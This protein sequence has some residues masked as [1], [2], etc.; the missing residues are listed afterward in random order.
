MQGFGILSSMV[1]IVP[2]ISFAFIRSKITNRSRTETSQPAPATNTEST[3][4][5]FIM[6]ISDPQAD[7]TGADSDP[8]AYYSA[9]GEGSFSQNALSHP[10]PA[11]TA[12][13]EEPYYS[14]ADPSAARTIIISEGDSAQNAY[15]YPTTTGGGGAAGAVAAGDGGDGGGGDGG[16]GGDG[17]GGGGGG[18]GGIDDDSYYSRAL[19]METGVTVAVVDDQTGQ[20]EPPSYVSIIA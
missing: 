4:T 1:F 6:P 9:V 3:P 7:V 17:G 15:D 13:V 10:Q 19:R 11:E 18:G 12:A 2:A 20:D 16:D 8:P 5:T 14:Q